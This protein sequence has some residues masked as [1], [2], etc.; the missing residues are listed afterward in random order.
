MSQTKIGDVFKEI[1]KRG[2]FGGEKVAGDYLSSGKNKKM[3]VATVFI[4]KIRHGF[5]PANKSSGL[6]KRM[7]EYPKELKCK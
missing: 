2:G 6:N 4:G 1:G 3:Y 7:A 5:I